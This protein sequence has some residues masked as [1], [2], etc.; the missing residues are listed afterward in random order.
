MSPHADRSLNVACWGFGVLVLLG[1]LIPWQRRAMRRA[2]AAP[3][4]GPCEVRR[5]SV[6][7][8]WSRR[9][10]IQ[11]ALEAMEGSDVSTAEGMSRFARHVIETLEANREAIRYAAWQSFQLPPE[12][13]EG[14]VAVLEQDLARRFTHDVVHSTSPV[15][16]PEIQA[17]PEEGE[18]LVVVS[19]VVGSMVHLEPLPTG[20]APSSV[21]DA[22]VTSLPR[23]ADD[24]VAFHVVW[25][26]AVEE[27]RMSSL[28]LE[29]NYPELALLD[30]DDA[31]GRHACT[32]C[33]GVYPKELVQCP[34]CGAP[35]V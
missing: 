34:A 25:S 20:L 33:R 29:A 8:D 31:L 23:A 24:L 30:P 35:R 28:E 4:E 13:A 6:A 19:I 18:G 2:R 3:T 9:A 7:F 5:V 27:D 16:A 12:S 10:R 1:L 32:H 26:P 14:K 11:R 15:D 17:R 22:I 21:R